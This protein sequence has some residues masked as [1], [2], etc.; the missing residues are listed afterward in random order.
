MD[1]L[2]A[3]WIS[4]PMVALSFAAMD[5]V[6]TREA[7]D[8]YWVAVA[9]WGMAVCLLYDV[10][11]GGIAAA[12]FALFAKALLT[13]CFLSPKVTGWKAVLV[14][15]SAAASS[16]AAYASDPDVGMPAAVSLTIVI[17]Y[18]AMY[19]AGR[20]VGG[21]D[22]KCLM[23]LAVCFPVY[24][25]DAPLWESPDQVSSL[26]LS[27]SFSIFATALLLSMSSA[28][29]TAIRNIRRGRVCPSMF[30]TL[31]MDV[32][33]AYGSFVWPVERIENGVKVRC[34]SCIDDRENVLDELRKAGHE[35]VLVTPMIPFLLPIAAAAGIILLFGNP[36][37]ALI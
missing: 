16:T 18:Y 30:G 17:L 12:C 29:I 6:R 22:V 20:S 32:S 9:V 8:G 19:A 35:Q 25:D 36:I 31:H 1:L 13:I 37:F 26:L 4:V 27:P 7:S 15:A 14:T 33:K 21:A 34:P 23:S 5:D 24:P 2:S 3:A 11:R 10:S 28:V